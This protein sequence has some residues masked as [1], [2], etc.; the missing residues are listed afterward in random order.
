MSAANA[1]HTQALPVTRPSPALMSFFDLYFTRYLRRHFHSFLIAHA[2]RLAQHQAPLI[3]YINHASW[4]D[5]LASWILGRRFLPNTDNYGPMDA[6]A[7]NRYKIL[8][9]LGLF[10]VEQGTHRGAAQFLNASAQILATRSNLWITPQGCFS[11]VRSRPINFRP[12]LGALIA[13][14]PQACAVP[15]A[16]EYTFWEE[17]LPEILVNVG[18]PMH[19]H[20]NFSTEEITSS[21]TAALART[22]DELAILAATRDA[23]RFEPVLKGNAGVSGVYELWRRLLSRLRGE[24]Y[25]PEHG[26]IH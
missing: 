2:A 12:G 7:L 11:D 3:I 8:R 22:Q 24:A 10:P 5:P 9:R 21:L 6:A 23:S 17:R 1:A 26:S 25:D 20:A 18:E 4:W 13:R 14:L 19:F 16:I 15:L